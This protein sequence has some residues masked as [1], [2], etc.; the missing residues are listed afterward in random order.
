MRVRGLVTA[1][2]DAIAPPTDDRS[3]AADHTRR[4]CAIVARCDLG[5]E[6]HKSV[7]CDLGISLRQFY[8]DRNEACARLA[9]ALEA[10]LRSEDDLPATSATDDRSL[11]FWLADSLQAVGQFAAAATVLKNVLL[12]SRRPMDRV[13]AYHRLIEVLCGAGRVTDAQA[14]LAR[15]KVETEVPVAGDEAA[16]LRAETLACEAA[17]LWHTGGG[18]PA[19]VSASRGIDVLRS[20]AAAGLPRARALLV[21]LQLT[22]ATANRESG[23]FEESAKLLDRARACLG[24]DA[25]ASTRATLLLNSGYTHVMMPFGV[26]RATEENAEALDI[27]KRNGLVRHAAAA[28]GNLSVIHRMRGEHDLAA[29]YGRK[30]LIFTEPIATREDFANLAMSVAQI[31]ADAGNGQRALELL[32]RARLH[33]GTSD[34]LAPRLKLAEA[35]VLVASYEFESALTIAKSALLTLERF[36]LRRRVGMALCTQA[37]AY[38]ALG[39]RRL[40][41]STI[42]DAVDALEREG[43][44]F[45][46]ARAYRTSARITGNQKHRAYAADLSAAMRG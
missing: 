18:A 7:A 9:S 29:S 24:P 17:V 39:H 6:P 46:L 28:L 31:E 15:A 45:A 33:A 42:S 3:R 23:E 38:A 22:L 21:D 40:A 26:R 36:G 44:A 5:G 16:L 10:E 20:L 37:E 34:S 41:C 14:V 11:Q 4:L 12:E 8:R 43:S 2:L 27:A 30:A 35:Y 25:S 19:T 13:A 32:A 1:A